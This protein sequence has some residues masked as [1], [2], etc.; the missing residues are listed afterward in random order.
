VPPPR[1]DF[2]YGAAVYG[3]VLVTA[4]VGSAFESHADS[5]TMTLT[6][7]GTTVVFWLAHVWSEVVGRRLGGL[8]ASWR[9]LREVVVSEWP[10]VEAGFLPAGLLGLAWLGVYSRDTGAELALAASLLQLVGW[11]FL[12]GWRSE[13]RLGLALLTGVVDGVLGLA[14]VG[15]EIAIH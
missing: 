1:H 4:L 3:S 10:I 7:L 14:I 5:R 12:A 6:L 8:S 9:E 11:G 2:A 15:L 13:H